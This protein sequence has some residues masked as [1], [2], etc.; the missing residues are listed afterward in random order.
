MKKYCTILKEANYGMKT[1]YEKWGG[2]FFV[3]AGIV[4][5]AWMSVALFQPTQLKSENLANACC[6]GMVTLTIKIF[7]LKNGWKIQL[8]QSGFGSYPRWPLQFNLNFDIIKRINEKIRILIYNA[9]KNVAIQ[10][11]Q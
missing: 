9:A 3:W 11:I 7:F 4:S 2:C 5:R 8:I 1:A 10:Y 6:K